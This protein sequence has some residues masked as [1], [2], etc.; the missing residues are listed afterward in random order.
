MPVV[1]V[2]NNTMLVQDDATHPDSSTQTHATVGV[3]ERRVVVDEWG[4][5]SRRS[6]VGC[7]GATGP[8]DVT[9]GRFPARALRVTAR[10]ARK[11]RVMRRV[12]HGPL[13]AVRVVSDGIA[14][15]RGGWGRERIHSA[16]HVRGDEQ[17][18]DKHTAHET[19]C[20][21]LYTVDCMLSV[22]KATIHRTDGGR[23]TCAGGSR[24]AAGGARQR[25]SGCGA[26]REL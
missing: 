16:W 22:I 1:V 20:G 19:L 5:V 9:F 15:W 4:T 18:E 12:V 23:A 11:Q 10:W 14:Q 2:E 6:L 17:G 7:V 3:I 26:G 21:S 25:C 24:D 8:G 13:A